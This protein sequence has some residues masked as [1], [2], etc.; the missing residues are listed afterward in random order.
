MAKM[1]V[2]GEKITL[3]KLAKSAAGNAISG[4]ADSTLA[5]LKVGGN[6]K[7]VDIPKG[8]LSSMSGSFIGLSAKAWT[9]AG[10]KTLAGGLTEF[11]NQMIDKEGAISKISLTK[12]AA[13]SS[14]SAITTVGNNYIKGP[15]ETMGDKKGGAIYRFNKSNEDFY[16]SLKAAE[17][18]AVGYC[19]N[20]IKAEHLN[21][22]GDK[23]WDWKDIAFDTAKDNREDLKN[24]AIQGL[25][26][27]V[28]HSAN[29][30]IG[31]AI[32]YVYIKPH[33]F[34]YEQCKKY[35]SSP[36]IQNATVPFK[37][38]YNFYGDVTDFWIIG[39]AKSFSKRKINQGIEIGKRELRDHL[40]LPEE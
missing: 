34:V 17:K 35:Y 36:F 19:V 33:I 25:P 21:S 23:D 13:A 27:L 30:P 9:E 2:N 10:V 29:E 7:G 37:A 5:E 31:I 39:D 14:V 18:F 22:K 1:G 6:V 28:K 32:N 26:S 3:S 38:V 20:Y 8:S 15:D 40:T 24:G 4:I 16:F 11:S 12:I